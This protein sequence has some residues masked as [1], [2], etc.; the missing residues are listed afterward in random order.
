MQIVKDKPLCLKNFNIFINSLNLSKSNFKL[1][2][3]VSAGVDSMSLLHLSSMW[4]KKNNKI[5]QVISFNHNIR[6]ESEEEVNLV[7]KYSKL[8]GWKH[9]ILK[10]KTPSKSNILENARIA[11][12]SAISDYCRSENIKILLSGHH[13]DDQLETFLLRILKKSNI[14]GLCPM[15]SKRNLFGIQIVRPF[16]NV[17][18]KDIYDY[19][20]LN[21]IKFCEDPTNHDNKYLRTKIRN[22]LS[23]NPNIKSKLIRCVNIFCKIRK[24]TDTQ[25]SNF[26]KGNIS[27]KNEGYI[28]INKE[29]LIMLPNFLI[30]NILNKAITNTGNKKYPLRTRSLKK[31]N[32]LISKN[33]YTTLSIGGCLVENKQKIIRIFREFNQ[34]KNL[35]L[36]VQAKKKIEWDNK[37]TITNLLSKESIIVI[38]FGKEIVKNLLLKRLVKDVYKKKLPYQAIKTVPVIKTLE[39]SIY[40][41]H[42]N[43][44]SDKYLKVNILLETI[45]FC[46][47]YT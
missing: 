34:V 7:A 45:D 47:I 27:V 28:E 15:L 43:I 40:V 36:K 44:S 9:K 23:T 29:N 20:I 5:L 10:W 11:R 37:F 31:L 12:Y 21:K 17:S 41:P 33:I 30:N 14:R 38:S 35:S 18:K 32:M 13:L 6:K 39:G 16:L 42:L 4:A 3:S 26:F 22:F 8:L 2:V 19:A 46:S 1:A 25:T 24:Y